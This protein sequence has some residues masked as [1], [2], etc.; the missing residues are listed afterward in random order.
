MTPRNSSSHRSR[1]RNPHTVTDRPH[2]D[3]NPQ[4]AGAKWPSRGSDS[5]HPR[6]TY[7]RFHHAE[8]SNNSTPSEW[9]D[10]AANSLLDPPTVGSAREWDEQAPT[11]PKGL[12]TPPAQAFIPTLCILSNSVSAS[13]EVVVDRPIRIGRSFDCDIRLP[14]DPS[15][16]RL[17]AIIAPEVEGLCIEDLGSSNGTFVN[18]QRVQ[19]SSLL[20][21]D[22][23][24][25]GDTR[26]LVRYKVVQAPSAI[27]SEAY[28]PSPPGS[29]DGLRAWRKDRGLTQTELANQLGVSQRTI[30]M[31]EQGAPIS[32]E[33]LKNLREKM[34]FPSS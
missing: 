28:S 3:H 8:S 7:P 2:P 20:E 26:I 22:R 1:P 16:S 31:W 11:N 24:R 30:S 12:R 33:N 17:H 13:V 25:L 10:T 29:V 19:R 6:P 15:L 18:N 9:S 32:P 34:G 5:Q 4:T 14:S 23:I 21:D 27:S